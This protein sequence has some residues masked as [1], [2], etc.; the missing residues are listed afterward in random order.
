MSQV[1][2]DFSAEGLR[3]I[4]VQS[5][6]EK[7]PPFFSQIVVEAVLQLKPLKVAL[8]GSR[9]RGDH[10]RQSDYDFCFWMNASSRHGWQNYREWVDSNAET[11]APIDLVDWD[12]ASPDL[13]N[14][15]LKESFVIY[16]Q[17]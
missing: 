11:L 13:K 1:N 5:R 4:P 6:L 3:D 16:E 14:S 8:F 7:C 10:R 9:A 2:A 17:N 12:E 15:I